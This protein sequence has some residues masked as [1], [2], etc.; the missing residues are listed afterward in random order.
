M[1]GSTTRVVVRQDSQRRGPSYCRRSFGGCN[2]VVGAKMHEP[3][4]PHRV[5]AMPDACACVWLQSKRSLTSTAA[6]A[7]VIQPRRKKTK[8]TRRRRTQLMRLASTRRCGSAPATAGRSAAAQPC[9]PRRMKGQ[10]T[11]L[12]GKSN[13]TTSDSG[14]ALSLSRAS[15]KNAAGRGRMWESVGDRAHLG[16][17]RATA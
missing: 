10:C 11:Q 17:Q 6:I 16:S 9:R 4:P 2:P 14:K 5:E 7:R 3:A 13:A 1:Q 12:R 15:P 8:K